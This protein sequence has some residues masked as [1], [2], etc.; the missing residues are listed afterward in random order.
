MKAHPIVTEQE[1]EMCFLAPKSLTSEIVRLRLALLKFRRE[2][3]RALK[4]LQNPRKKTN[5]NEHN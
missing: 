3:D 4:R 1:R 5:H 2:V